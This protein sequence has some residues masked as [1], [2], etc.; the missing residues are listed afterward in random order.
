MFAG[1]IH[2]I[3]A[4]PILVWAEPI[5]NIITSD[6]AVNSMISELQGELG[7]AILTEWRY[8]SDLVVVPELYEDFERENEATDYVDVVQVASLL[9][10]AGTSDPRAHFEW[11][12]LPS[13]ARLGLGR[14]AGEELL[15]SAQDNAQNLSGVLDSG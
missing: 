4:L 15:E 8:P 13:A 9:S 11:W 12:E 14:D 6:D 1:L 5:P 3:G 7:R 10:F 2:N